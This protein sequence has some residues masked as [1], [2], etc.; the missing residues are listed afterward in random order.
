MKILSL[1]IPYGGYVFYGDFHN[2]SETQ[3][4]RYYYNKIE[5]EFN[6]WKFPELSVLNDQGILIILPNNTLLVN[7]ISPSINANIPILKDTSYITITNNQPVKLSD[8]N[9]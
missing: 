8:G 4:Y 5:N 6:D 2:T 9:I 1:N 7:S 3:A